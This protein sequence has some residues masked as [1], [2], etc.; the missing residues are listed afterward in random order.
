MGVARLIRRA[1]P[2]IVLGLAGVVAARRRGERMRHAQLSPPPFPPP[3]AT[4]EPVV[5]AEPE[6]R[7]ESKPPEEPKPQ[8]S[9]VEEP[10]PEVPEEPQ[11]VE[12]SSVTDIV[13]DLL[14]P[15]ESAERIEDVTLVEGSALAEEAT[16]GDEELAAAVR[17]ALAEQPGLLP[18][19]VDIEVQR[20]VVHLSGQVERGEAITELERRSGEVPGV[21]SVRSLLHLPGTRPPAASEHL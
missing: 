5:E 18:G 7:E 14:A 2:L 19:T 11:V 16:P 15:W 10:E 3:V 6:A 1:S 8:E 12:A 17:R 4:A 21:R 9:E 13:D 20:G